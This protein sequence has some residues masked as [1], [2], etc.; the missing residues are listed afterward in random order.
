[1]FTIY[2]F[3]NYSFQADCK[4]IV[5]RKIDKL[6]ERTH[7][8]TEFSVKLINLE[9]VINSVLPSFKNRSQTYRNFQFKNSLNSK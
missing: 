3:K 7:G 6:Q 1:M 8:S 2:L 9:H 4:E 5:R